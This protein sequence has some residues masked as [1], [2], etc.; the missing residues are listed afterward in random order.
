[1]LA[2]SKSSGLITCTAIKFSMRRLGVGWGVGRRED[3]QC[4]RGGDADGKL[5]LNP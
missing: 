3:D 4:E 5:E 1:M 2:F